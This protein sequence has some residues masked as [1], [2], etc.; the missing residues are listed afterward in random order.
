MEFKHLLICLLL[1]ELLNL[2]DKS[3]DLSLE[4]INKGLLGSAEFLKLSD[5]KLRISQLRGLA[6]KPGSLII[7]DLVEE[8]NLTLLAL[9][10]LVAIPLSGILSGVSSSWGRRHRLLLFCLADVGGHLVKVCGFHLVCFFLFF[11]ITEFLN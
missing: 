2:F 11:I 5:P 4:L 9:H 1:S 3:R 8:S 10:E 6:V 7:D